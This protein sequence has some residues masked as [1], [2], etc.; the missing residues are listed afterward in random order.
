[1]RR[2][3]LVVLASLGCDDGGAG[4]VVMDAAGPDG[5]A[6]DAALADLG[7]ADVAPAP[8]GGAP[9][10]DASPDSVAPDAAP[11]LGSFCGPCGSF[12]C[13]AGGLCLTNEQTGEQF[14]GRACEASADCPGGAACTVVDGRRQCVP[15]AGSCREGWTGRACDDDAGCFGAADACLAAGDRSYCAPA[16]EADSGC[17]VGFARCV[18]GRCRADW[19]LGPEGCGVVDAPGNCACMERPPEEAALD[20]ALELAGID[21]CGARFDTTL[22]ALF[23]PAVSRDP[24]RL[25]WTNPAHQA[26]FHGLDFARRIR[27]AL[28][29]DGARREPLAALIAR[30]A[31]LVDQ[32]VVGEPTPAGGELEAAL[33]AV[34]GGRASD[35]DGVPDALRAAIARVLMAEVAV[36]EARAAALAAAGVT[37]QYRQALFDLMPTTMATAGTFQG[38]NFAN[39]ELKRL[40]TGGLDLRGLYGAARDLAATIEAVDWAA[41]AGA[42]GFA[43]QV[44]TPLGAIVVRDAGAGTLTLA[45]PALL[46]VDTGGDDRYEGPVAATSTL[47]NPVSVLV[48]IGG[49]DHYGYVGSDGEPELPGGIPPADAAGRYDG[50][51]PQVGDAFGPMSNSLVARQGAGILGVG[52]LVDIAGDDDYRSLKVSPGAGVLGV[53]AL[54]DRGGNDLYGCEQACQGAGSWGVGLLVDSDGDDRYVGIQSVQGFAYVRAFGYLHDQ[55][56]DD[57][58][59]ALTGD[60]QFGGLQV[61]P[62]PQNPGGSNTSFAQGA[63]FGRRGD[64]DG[65]YASGG[66][67]AFRDSGDGADRYTVD[68]FGQGTGYW[69][70]AGLFSDGGGDDV[71]SGRW[72]TQGSGAHFAL[73]W[74]FEEGGDDVYNPNGEVLAT[75]VGQGHDFSVG[76]LIDAAGDDEYHAPGLGMGGGNDNGLGFFWDLAG[77]DTYDASDGRTFGG[78]AIGD[79][80]AAFDDALCLGIFVDG[81]G[82][83]TYPRF[84]EDAPV[85]E[86]KRWSLDARRPDHKPGERGGGLDLP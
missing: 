49:N 72:Y 11:A 4:S 56:G 52:L 85:G 79:R 67:G 8:D 16:C 28:A 37:P 6:R 23:D 65:V 17:P 35:F 20:D 63:G 18:E 59:L 29:A 42:D 9:D 47:D 19:E 24:F 86:G 71:Y 36:A 76:W 39:E 21:R 74:F 84:A 54:H 34:G 45:G 82:A 53:G 51:H 58:Y 50:S 2:T 73:S 10:P 40:L 5:S 43:V 14:C 64:A 15:P 77:A 22:L 70:G 31:E 66:L 1:M 62:N 60:P 75:A 61:Y 13:E 55:A 41:F 80:G 7:A 78:A 69:Y 68:I 33:V 12:G 81:G 30:G 48:E 26:A 83:D 3:V 38:L 44:D 32:P 46:V 57:E 25:S 27:A